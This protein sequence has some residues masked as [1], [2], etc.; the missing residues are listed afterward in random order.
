M[1]AELRVLDASG[2]T[3]TIWDPEN[4]D[5]VAVAKATFDALK[6]KRY[7]IYSVGKD[8]KKNT[9]MSAFDPDAGKLIA[10]PPVVGG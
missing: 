6:A 1:E 4:A 7:L 9:A 2:D 10:V 3:K 5:E 8:G